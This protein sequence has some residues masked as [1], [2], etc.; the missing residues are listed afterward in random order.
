MEPQLDPHDDDIHGQWP[1]EE[2]N[3]VRSVPD[4]YT[5]T[6]PS[7]SSPSTPSSRGRI[8]PI[9]DTVQSYQNSDEEQTP[10]KQPKTKKTPPKQ[11]KSKKTP[12][13]PS[14][15]KKTMSTAATMTLNAG[16][17]LDID[18]IPTTSSAKDNEKKMRP[19][20]LSVISIGI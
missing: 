16:C 15:T 5:L 17:D 14:K 9:A 19:R 13:K 11:S 8:R 12:P 18:D 6:T 3:M 4:P 20:K 7:S 10:S 1:N 2:L